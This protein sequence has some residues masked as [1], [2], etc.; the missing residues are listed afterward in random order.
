M[1]C[2]ELMKKMMRGVR[3]CYFIEGYCEFCFL[4]YI[5]FN[6]SYLLMFDSGMSEVTVQ[7]VT[8]GWFLL[9]FPNPYVGL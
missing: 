2:L 7:S 5:G 3:I 4:Y 1:M 9:N 6:F 8:V